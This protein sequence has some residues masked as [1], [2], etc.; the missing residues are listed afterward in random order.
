MLDAREAAADREFAALTEMI[1]RERGFRCGSY[2]E[3]CLRR[4][5]AVRMRAKGVHTFE[6]YAHVLD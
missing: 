1:A 3:R 2:K 6:Q 5:I 4:R